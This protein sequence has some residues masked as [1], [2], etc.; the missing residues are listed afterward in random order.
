MKSN[1]NSYET[2][3]K[4]FEEIKQE[5]EF[6]KKQQLDFSRALDKI[7]EII[8]KNEKPNDLLADVNDILGETLQ[9]DRALIYYVSAKEQLIIGLC[10]WLNK[11]DPS[12][13]PT[14]DTY[15]LNYFKVSY[16][17]LVNKRKHIESHTNAPAVSFTEEGSDKVLHDG[18]HIKSLL[19]YP[20]DFENGNFYLFALNQ[21]SHVRR[22]TNEEI[23]F[24]S[25]A[26]RHVSMALMKIKLNKERIKLKNKEEVLKELNATKDKIFSIISHDLRSPFNVLLGYNQLLIENAEKYPAEK[27]RQFAQEMYNSSK[28]AFTLLENLLHWSSLQTGKLVPGPEELIPS[29]LF[30]DLVSIT[31]GQATEKE[32]SLKTEIHSNDKV[33]ADREMTKTV[34]RNLV[35]N[36]IK[37]SYPGG[38]ITIK[39]ER[40]DNDMLFTVSDTGIGIEKAYVSGIFNVDCN[41]SKPGTSNESGTG[42][43][44]ILC[45]DFVE[46]NHGSIW[47]ESE[48]GKGSDFKFTLPVFSV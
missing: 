9:L 37:Y 19:W 2:L 41:I 38:A 33:R 27:V 44:L 7:A 29:E 10:E 40:R 12:I 4:Q 16:Q 1:N 20:F 23:Q 21:L 32:I 14:I 22:W 18:M 15:P 11:E 13:Q 26:A 31:A 24:V 6:H 45:K 47:A 34:L 8:L 39:A 42:L 5:N 25:S 28:Q 35:T 3:K 30:K 46:V 17:K 36:A 43:G 48:P